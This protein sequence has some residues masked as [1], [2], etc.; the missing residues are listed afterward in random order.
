MFALDSNAIIHAFQGKGGVA[1][2]LTAIPPGNIS[3]PAVALFEVECGVLK[4]HNS[5]RRRR[6]LAQLTGA[7]RVLHFDD[8]VAGIAA[9]I[10]VDLERRGSKIGPLDTL[11]AATALANGAILI[12]HNTREFG[13]VPGLQIED[14][15]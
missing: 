1:K 12:T 5:A 6:Q 7:C 13:R 15:Y 3:I 8:K 14:W 11:I 4:S 10:Q 9:R 2:R